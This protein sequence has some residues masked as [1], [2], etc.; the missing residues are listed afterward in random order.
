LVKSRTVHQYRPAKRALTLAAFLAVTLPPAISHMTAAHAAGSS[1]GNG[2]A[3]PLQPPSAAA[4]AY[5]APSTGERAFGAVKPAERGRGAPM[6][7]AAYSAGATTANTT[8]GAATAG[9]TAPAASVDF[10]QYAPPIGNQGSVNACM[11]WVTN[12]YLRG[13]YARRDGYYPAGGNPATGSFEPMYTY[14]QIVNGQNVGTSLNSNLDLMQGQGTDARGDYTQGDFDYTDKPTSGETSNAAQYK[15]GGWSNVPTGN[16]LQQAIETALSNGNPVGLGIAVYSNFY[17]ANSASYYVDAPPSGMTYYGS[18]GVTAFKYDANGVWVANQWGTS[19]GL[20]GWA[21]LSWAF[22]NNSSDTWQA[23]TMTPAATNTPT[24]VVAT[25]T[26]LPPTAT[27]TP[28]PPANTATLVTPTAT[29]TNTP[30]PP[31]ATATP[32][33]I[34]PTA[35]NTATSVPPTATPTNTPIPPT[36][37]NTVAPIPPTATNTPVPPTA[38]ATA[39]NTPV[40][41]TATATATNTPV[42]PTATPPRVPP[43]A[44]NTATSVPPTAMPPNIPVP[45]TAAPATLFSTGFESGQPQP[46]WTNTVDYNGWGGGRYNIGGICCGLTGPEVGP[47]RERTRAGT[48]ALMYSGND[49]GAT[50]S[51]VYDKIFDASARAIAI[52]PTTTL[53]YWIYPQSS[54]TSPV[55]VYGSN[56]AC[57]AIDMIFGDGS[58]LRDSGVTDQNGVR[59]HPGL[60]CRHLTL[61]TWNHVVAVLG[62]KLAGKTINRIN[63]GYDQA[64]NTGGYRGYIDDISIYN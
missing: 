47:R 27:Y 25:S 49:T 50:G 20:N 18:H 34:P 14:A 41:P 28:I 63:V 11:A 39:T 3:G 30:V 40:P 53:S 21:E 60:Q 46:T 35:A 6:A 12:Y 38:T 2:L 61:N 4:H 57:V 17:G 52:G 33:P 51:F 44:T 55:P 48:M 32:P 59:L 45:P 42:P 43:V 8:S 19:W 62:T 36:A 10:S 64:A 37:T 16:G 5:G 9:S 15:I 13:Y 7:G 1:D 54:A 29:A 56:S 58:N 23:V 22:I 24:Q 31:T 26:P